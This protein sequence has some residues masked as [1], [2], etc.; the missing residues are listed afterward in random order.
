MRWPKRRKRKPAPWITNAKCEI[1]GCTLPGL[2]QLGGH[3][4][5]LSHIS[6]IIRGRHGSTIQLDC[7]SPVAAVSDRRT[8]QRGKISKETF[9]L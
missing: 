3:N 7:V 5:C 8:P 4:F 6:R 9:T 1:E 2:V